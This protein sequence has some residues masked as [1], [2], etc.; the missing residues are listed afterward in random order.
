M[1][2]I[3]E[4]PAWSAGEVHWG[5]AELADPRSLLRTGPRRP[6]WVGLGTLVVKLHGRTGPLLADPF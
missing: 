2:I 3:E 5:H 4:S 1:Q 6:F